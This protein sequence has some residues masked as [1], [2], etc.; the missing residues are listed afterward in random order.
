MQQLWIKPYRTKSKESK[1]V[2]RTFHLL[3]VLY[4][5]PLYRPYY[6]RRESFEERSS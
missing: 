6:L 1:K 3:I 2:K 5:I 4:V